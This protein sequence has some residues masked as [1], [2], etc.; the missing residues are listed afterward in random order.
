MYAQATKLQIIKMLGNALLLR[1]HVFPAFDKH[2]FSELQQI[3]E[4]SFIALIDQ[5]V[6]SSAPQDCQK[7]VEKMIRV[8]ETRLLRDGWIKKE[9][10][11]YWIQLRLKYKVEIIS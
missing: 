1:A 3:G 4:Q 10:K 7:F 2:L 8:V 5:T 11:P 6:S 9:P